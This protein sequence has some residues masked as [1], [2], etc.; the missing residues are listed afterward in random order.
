SRTSRESHLFPPSHEIRPSD[1]KILGS[2]CRQSQPM[3][4]L[5]HVAQ[6]VWGCLWISTFEIPGQFKQSLV[7]LAFLGGN[8]MGGYT[9]RRVQKMTSVILC[10]PL[11]S[12]VL[13]CRCECIRYRKKARKLGNGAIIQRMAGYGEIAGGRVKL[14]ADAVNDAFTALWW[15]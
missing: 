8:G 13:F 11:F 6:L 10:S 4:F 1:G 12:S 2:D 14:Y 7:A 9:Y 3:P 15:R 5:H